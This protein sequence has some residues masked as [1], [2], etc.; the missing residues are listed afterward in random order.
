MDQLRNSIKIIYERKCGGNNFDEE[1]KCNC[2][3]H[4]CG[5]GEDTFE[6][7]EP[8]IEYLYTTYNITNIN[9]KQLHLF[10]FQT[11]IFI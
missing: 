3:L 8:F 4:S 6:K 1:D 10:T 11:P 9:L 2:F 7:L 5:N